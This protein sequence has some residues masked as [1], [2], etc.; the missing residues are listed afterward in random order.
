MPAIVHRLAVAATVVAFALS[1]AACTDASPRPTAAAAQTAA[2]PIFASDEEALAAAEEAYSAYLGALDV[3][4]SRGGTDTELLTEVATSKVREDL[5]ASFEAMQTA[6]VHTG[7]A[8]VGTLREL[9]ENA[10]VGRTAVVSVYACL[11]VANVR[12]FDASGNDVTPAGRPAVT[13]HQ[14]TMESRSE[15]SPHLLVSESEVW[16]GDDFCS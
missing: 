1:T 11:N 10:L 15:G 4:G 8:T 6:G 7:G 3:V 13:P 14:V 5:E 9:V 12:V 2:A 16:R